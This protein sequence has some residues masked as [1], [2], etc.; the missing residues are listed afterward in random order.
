MAAPRASP[1]TSTPVS[2][3]HPSPLK[4]IWDCVQMCLNW[5]VL[6]GLAVVGLAVWVVAP[7]FVLAALPL[8]LVVS[9]L[10]LSLRTSL[11]ASREATG[12]DKRHHDRCP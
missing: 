9:G 6:A 1:V 12:R 8:L 11:T 7:Q 5:K 3:Q 4:A 10:S 2:L